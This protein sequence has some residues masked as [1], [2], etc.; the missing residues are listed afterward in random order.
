MEM[1]SLDQFVVDQGTDILHLRGM[2]N[3]GFWSHYNITPKQIV[4]KNGN[5]ASGLVGISFSDTHQ[6]YL[7]SEPTGQHTALY[8]IKFWSERN[9]VVVLGSPH[10]IF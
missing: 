4:T 9:E 8:E 6:Q 1:R 10:P 3:N 7:Y 5:L 2:V